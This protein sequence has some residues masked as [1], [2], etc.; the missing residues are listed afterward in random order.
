MT[1]CLVAYI[2]GKESKKYLRQITITLLLLDL[3]ATS[4]FILISE[5]RHQN[6]PIYCR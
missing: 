4:L 6:L 5:E 2:Q 3:V 1:I